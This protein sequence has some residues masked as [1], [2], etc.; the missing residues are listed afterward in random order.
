MRSNLFVT[1]LLALT[2][3]GGASEALAAFSIANSGFDAQDGS[4]HLNSTL[5]ATGWFNANNNPNTQSDTLINAQNGA[6]GGWDANGFL[7]GND[8]PFSVDGTSEQSYIY[9]SIGAYSGEGS[10]TV[11]GLVFNRIL[12]PILRGVGNFDVSIYYTGAGAFTPAVGN[13]IALSGTLVGSSQVFTNG[14]D[15]NLTT[16]TTSQK[17]SWSYTASFGGS[18]VASGNEVW[19]RIGDGGNPTGTDWDEPVIDNLN[20]APF[21][22]GDANGDG[23]ATL[24]DFAAIK[25]NFR[26]TG[27]TR[28]Q[29]DVDTSGDVDFLDYLQWRRAFLGG[30]GVAADIP[31]LFGVPEPA[32]EILMALSLLG[33]C[34]GLSAKRRP[35]TGSSRPFVL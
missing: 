32:S 27:T 11:T 29:G 6:Q 9:Q 4:V 2:A 19:L 15:F 35:R 20:I 12:N 5:S 21:V 33:A 25:A 13:D 31:A 23:A 8:A 30:G 22:L 10:V 17:A 34:S 24:T 28:A 26:L 18:G 3:V 7:F 14:V 1:G 16:N